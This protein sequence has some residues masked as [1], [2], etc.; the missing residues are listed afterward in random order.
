MQL[1]ENTIK[2]KGYM[3]ID[4]NDKSF[5]DTDDKTIT[6]DVV[7]A[8]SIANQGII[9][10]VHEVKAVH[11]SYTGINYTDDKDVRQEIEGSSDETWTINVKKSKTDDENYGLFVENVDI[12]LETK[13]INVDFEC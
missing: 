10:E 9:L 2:L 3:Q 1:I 13:V 7:F 6:L 11:W 4:L 8:V 5:E 12:N